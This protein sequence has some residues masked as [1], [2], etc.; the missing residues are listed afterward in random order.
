M[1]E[2]ANV[3][4][5]AN[6]AKR[7][8]SPSFPFIPLPVAVQRLAAFEDYFKRHPAPAR[9]AGLAWGM[10][11][12][13][14]QAGQTLAALKSF[15]LVEY[16][17][18]K[19]GLVASLSDDARNYLR[20]QQDSIKREILSRLALRPRLIAMY[21][22]KW[23]PDR[24]PDPVCLDDLVLKMSFNQAGAETF[25]KVYDA[26]IAFAGLSHSD[27]VPLQEAGGIDYDGTSE[28]GDVNKYSA[29][30][31][32]SPSNELAA[33]KHRGV[34]MDGEREL[35]T[36]LLSKGASFRLIVSGRIGEKEIER[37]IKKLELD[38]EILADQDD[39]DLDIDS[40]LPRSGP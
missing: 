21:W 27:I 32:Q 10:K 13:S 11:G 17:G 23:G 31:P 36:G 5:N 28:V 4:T 29:T 40:N 25:L 38:K 9:R 33:Q 26:T 22:E 15:G 35:T 39:D 24:P 14:S 19:D 2:P 34:L 30:L 6:K 16:S 20:A 18:A 1:S 8:R 3:E 7:E 12:D 37:L